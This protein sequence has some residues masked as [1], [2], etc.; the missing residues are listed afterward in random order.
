M[1]LYEFGARVAILY[2]PLLLSL[3]IHEYAHGLVAKWFGDNTATIRGRLT[4]N[5]LP[6]M[7]M[8]GTFLLPLSMIYFNAGIIGWGVPVPVDERNMKNPRADMFWVAFAGPISNILIAILSAFI[9][10]VIATYFSGSSYSS[11]IEAICYA[12]IKM[13]LLLAIFNLIPIHPLDGGKV[14]ARFLP[15]PV[16]RKLEE[17]QMVLGIILM[18][19]I[20]SG[21]LSFLF[22]PIDNISAI[23]VGFAQMLVR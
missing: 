16:N 11:G 5:P 19:L 10:A 7:D 17:N 21:M 8:I 13:N 6:H 1:N 9:F 22:A 14:L 23:L 18:V 20:F 3:T 2:I 12:M 4:L 15:E